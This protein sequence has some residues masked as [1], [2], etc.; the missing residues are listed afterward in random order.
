MSGAL[1]ANYPANIYSTIQ[2][3][4]MTLITFFAEIRNVKK[5]SYCWVS[6][7]KDY[8]PWTDMFKPTTVPREA[9]AW[10]LRTYADVPTEICDRA[11]H[12]KES[13]ELRILPLSLTTISIF[14]AQS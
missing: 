5:V 7:I 6:R 10:L 2:D 3:G 14:C 9:Q 8:V 4:E 1:L 12:D 13:V 11:R